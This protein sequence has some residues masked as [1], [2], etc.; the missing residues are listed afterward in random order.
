[1]T[2]EDRHKRHEEVSEAQAAKALREDPMLTIWRDEQ[3]D[4]VMEML[5]NA[6]PGDAGNGQRIMA[7]ARLAALY[8]LGASLTEKIA[9]GRMAEKQIADDRKREERKARL[10][11]VANG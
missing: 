9:T 8:D 6:A 1:M 3:K 7:Q 4:K 11:E 5:L 10:Q 2:P